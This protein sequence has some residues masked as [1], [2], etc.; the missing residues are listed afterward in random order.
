VK[1]HPL[2][3]L[4]STLYALRPTPYALR[5]TPY[6]LRSTLYAEGCFQERPDNQV[7]VTTLYCA[8]TM[9][10]VL[11]TM[12]EHVI[13]DVEFLKELATL[14]LSG[15]LEL[16]NKSQEQPF[17]GL[18][19]QRMKCSPLQQNMRGRRSGFAATRRLNQRT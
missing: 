18:M 2:Y 4:R 19:C 12:C 6:A 9:A 8:K 10:F 15:R 13:I 3:A 5:S 16:L 17:F 11:Q 1:A 7:M 14:N